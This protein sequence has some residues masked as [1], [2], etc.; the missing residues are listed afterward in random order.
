MSFKYNKILVIGSNSFTGSNYIDFA[1]TKSC[2]LVG[3]SRSN[4]YNKVMLPYKSNP[5]LDKFKFYKLD[6]NKHIKNV[7][8]C[9]QM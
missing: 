6:V 8:T 2:K 7:N 5:F 1:L 9:K 3:I 4:E